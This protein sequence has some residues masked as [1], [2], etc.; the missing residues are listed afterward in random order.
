[1]ANNQ[2]KKAITIDTL[3]IL[4]FFGILIGLYII[5]RILDILAIIFI[6]LIIATALNPLVNYFESKKMPRLLGTILT[7]LIV[8]FVLAL[9]VLIV[10]PPIANQI[11]LFYNA[12][13]SYINKFNPTYEFLSKRSTEVG[14]TEAIKSSLSKFVEQFGNVAAS[15]FQTTKGIVYAFTAILT[16]VIVSFYS[17]LGGKKI[18][19]AV[20][21]L[22][23]ARK[24]KLYQEIF[25]G[26][27]AK[28]GAWTRGQIILSLSVGI[29]ITIVLYFMRMP[30]VLALGLIAAVF[31]IIPV[32]GPIV[33]AIPAVLIALTISPWLALGVII[34]FIVV[35][36]I[37]NNILVPKIMGSAVGVP[38]LFAIIAVLVGGKLAGILGIL[39]A[40]PL[41]ASI[42]VVLKEIEEEK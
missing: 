25:S 20:L 22:F 38:P 23:P 33:A 16:I 24:R 37:E 3:T 9:I 12:L 10:A 39:V 18:K 14:L 42:V 36:Q 21:E 32:I 29:L 31:E 27:V 8:L 11:K 6:A 28:L 40:I 4:K 13:P 30:Y 7:Y 15:A 19:K 1:M 5:W 2:P 34:A 17:V 26:I 41:L 35:Q